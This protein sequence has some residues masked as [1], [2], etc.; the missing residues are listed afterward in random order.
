[1]EN[2]YQAKRPFLLAVADKAAASQGYFP[3][4]QQCEKSQSENSW[5]T[6]ESGMQ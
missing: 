1:M 6:L 4:S 2:K 3:P 5:Q